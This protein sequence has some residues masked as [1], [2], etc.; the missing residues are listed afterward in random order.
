MNPENINTAIERIRNQWPRA[1][2]DDAD[3]AIWTFELEQLDVTVSRETFAYFVRSSPDIRPTPA[4]FVAACTRRSKPAEPEN[5]HDCAPCGNTGWAQCDNQLYP[6]TTMVKACRCSNGQTVARI[7]ADD[8]PRS[9]K[10]LNGSTPKHL[11]ATQ[12][13]GAE[14]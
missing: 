4:E 3:Q 10:K 14:F 2:W 11:Q 8:G 7:L 13:Q 5:R 6:G 1:V 9:F 12:P